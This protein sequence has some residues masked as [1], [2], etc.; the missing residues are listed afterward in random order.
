MNM[1]I[2]FDSKKY[3]N[4]SMDLEDIER[5]IKADINTSAILLAISIVGLG[6]I[7]FDL[8]ELFLA[9]MGISGVFF[10]G[11]AAKNQIQHRNFINVESNFY[12]DDYDYFWLFE[13]LEML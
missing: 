12:L 1:M 6:F 7:E 10:L 9:I 11:K 13:G 5:N 4:K 3:E 8:L 2:A